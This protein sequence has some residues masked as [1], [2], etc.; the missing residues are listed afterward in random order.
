MVLVVLLTEKEND[1]LE[2]GSTLKALSGLTHFISRSSLSLKFRIVSW[3]L[4]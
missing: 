2:I 4:S 1:G 3:E